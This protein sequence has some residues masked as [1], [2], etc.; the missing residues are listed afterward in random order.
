MKLIILDRDGVINQDS[1]DFIKS[2]D[3]WLPI[4]GSLE[5]IARLNHEGWHVV[6]ASNQ[7]GI[8]RGL[9]DMTTLNAIH[10]KMH[11]ML[12]AAGGRI[13]AIFFCPHAPEDH[14]AC[15]KPKSGLFQDIAKR[16]ELETLDGVP[17]VGDSVRDLQA[18]QPLGCGLH[19]VR[20]GKGERIADLGN[21]P[22]GTRVHDDLAAFATWLLQQPKTPPDK[23]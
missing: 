2:P 23:A 17:A 13:D 21:L 19:L 7:S 11:K 8:G 10:R 5:A 6:V 15:R 20:T 3:E 1:D 18:A 9:F 16:Y 4:P 14:C 22:A 12:A